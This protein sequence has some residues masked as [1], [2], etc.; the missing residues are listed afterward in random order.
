MKYSLRKFTLNRPCPACEQGTALLF[1]TCPNCGKVIIACD[2]EGAIFH[3]PTDLSKVE[4]YSCEPWNST[5][6]RCPRCETEREFRLSRI[7]EIA[8]LGFSPEEY[9]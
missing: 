3:D 8:K 9:S 4:N 2:E 6:T 5:V 1:L 7:E